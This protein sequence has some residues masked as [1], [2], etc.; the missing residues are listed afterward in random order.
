MM[1]A[2][3]KI[4]SIII[5]QHV[6]LQVVWAQGQCNCADIKEGPAKKQID[7]DC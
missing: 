7:D 6:E 4:G 5:G 1:K 3:R 2:E